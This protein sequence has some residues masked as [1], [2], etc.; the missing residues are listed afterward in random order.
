VPIT[1]LDDRRRRSPTPRTRQGRA[2]RR[3]SALR[4]SAGLAVTAGLA[5][6]LCVSLA[7]ARSNRQA[8]AAIAHNIVRD[9]QRELARHVHEVPDGSNNSR[10]ITRYRTATV[11]AMR[12]APWCA[13]FV[14]Y[15]AKKAGVPIGWHGEGMGYVPY[16]RDWAHKTGRWRHTPKPGYLI[17]FPQHV[18]IVEHVYSNHTLTTIEG[19]TS[20]AVLRRWHRWGEAVGYV[21]LAQGGAVEAPS[22]PRPPTTTVRS[23]KLVPRIRIYPNAD[24]AIGETLD[25]SAQDSSGNIA[26]YRW[27][28]DG[29]GR[30]DSSTPNATHAWAKA[31]TYTVKLQVSDAK[32]HQKSTTKKVTV[33]ANQPPAASLSLGAYAVHVG[34]QVRMDASGS[35]DADGRIVRYDWDF[36][37]DGSFEQGGSRGSHVYAQPGTYA[38]RVRVTDDS[39]NTA[40]AEREV[41]VQAYDPPVASASCAPAA[42]SSGKTLYCTS[43]DSRSPYRVTKHDWDI[44]SDGTY[45][46]H[47]TRVGFRYTRPGDYTVHLRVTDTHGNT[48]ETDVPVQV[49]DV[50]PVVKITPPSPLRLNTPLTFD[51]GNST[52]SDG[53]VTAYEWDTGEG[54][55][56][57]ER[58]LTT[59]Y[60]STGS[61]T[62]RLRVT[63]D[64]GATTTT[65]YTFT[66]T[67]LAPTARITLPSPA[68]INA[69]L[70]FDG[71]ASSDPDG[72]IA[73]YDWDLDGNGTY[74]TTD[75]SPTFTYPTAGSRR[76]RL[77]VT[78]GLGASATATAWLTVGAP[79]AMGWMRAP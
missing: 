55:Q 40:E 66:L 33:H 23:Q 36:T 29:D 8:Q 24:A 5:L 28:F 3:V 13:Y 16:I 67:N 71:S 60:T 58:T 74:E 30:W 79:A 38:V 76:I 32:H 47:G 17:T 53:T 14:S 57:G 10:S 54:F 26:K 56:P 45:D 27:D 42:V 49:D 18:G 59:T 77:R 2:R 21:K 43:D 20:N 11:G 65:S 1:G 63:D 75:P 7:G 64:L 78:D 61:K 37:G 9:A 34:D 12:G 51:G 31:G 19:N 69:P 41:D 22:A 48:A 68:Y 6:L 39:G 15:I 50:P 73:R 4:R 35:R 70:T 25:L 44:Q 72:T 52:D 46:V 62:V